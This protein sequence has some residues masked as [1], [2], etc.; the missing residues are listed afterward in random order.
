MLLLLARMHASPLLL[1]VVLDQLLLQGAVSP[2]Q[3]AASY[4]SGRVN[5]GYRTASFTGSLLP[6]SYLPPLLAHPRPL[7]VHKYIYIVKDL[8]A[9]PLRG[10]LLVPELENIKLEDL[11]LVLLK[12]QLGLDMELERVIM[13]FDLEEILTQMLAPVLELA[14][15]LG[16]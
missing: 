10:K 2:S 4:G 7:Y 5:A 16:Q 3:F 15:M 11:K 8:L 9:L 13:A 6:T 1:L 14:R 12:P